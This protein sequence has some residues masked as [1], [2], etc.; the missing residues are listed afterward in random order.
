[1]EARERSVSTFLRGG[2]TNTLLTRT[3]F[4][5]FDCLNWK[6]R[7]MELRSIAGSENRLQVPRFNGV[8][9]TT[10]LYWVDDELEWI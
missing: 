6:S 7:G 8:V 3:L 2:M 4:H 1:M 9:A 10:L 5:K